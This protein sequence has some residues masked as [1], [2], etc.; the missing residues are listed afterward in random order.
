MG[1]RALRHV[2]RRARRR[3]AVAGR[4][5]V[6]APGARHAVLPRR[7]STGSRRRGWTFGVVEP[8]DLLLRRV[9]QLR[10]QPVAATSS[11]SPTRS[12]RST[13]GCRAP[14]CPRTPRRPPGRT[15][16]TCSSRCKA[17]VLREA[18]NGADFNQAEAVTVAAG[19]AAL[20]RPGPAGRAVRRRGPDPARVRGQ[21]RRPRPGRV[22]RAAP[23]DRPRA[24]GRDLDPGRAG[25]PPVTSRT[26]DVVAAAVRGAGAVRAALEHRLR[27]REVRAALRPA[28][29]C[30][31]P[32]GWPSP[33]CCSALLA[34][35]LRSAADGRRARSTGA[36][37]SSACCCTPATWA[38]PSSA[39]RA[40]SR[41]AWPRSS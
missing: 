9:R 16:T 40:G 37:P 13:S 31:S 36:P 38:A 32:S 35:A 39:S 19:A 3:G 6:G 25:L 34:A 7:C 4:P 17:A 12:G 21:L 11:R 8:L 22:H 27:R 29:H 30:S 2:D 33:P 5:A 23:G 1:D 14:R 24:G 26:R 10:A 28:V 41:P 20:H 15:R 18:H